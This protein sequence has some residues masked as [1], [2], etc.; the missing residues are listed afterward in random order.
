MDNFSG[1]E[2]LH[3]GFLGQQG[4]PSNAIALGLCKKSHVDIKTSKAKKADSG[5]QHDNQKQACQ[6]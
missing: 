3:E 6:H 5:T 1:I 4:V 2:R